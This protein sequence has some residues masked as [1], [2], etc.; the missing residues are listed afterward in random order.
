MLRRSSLLSMRHALALACAALIAASGC[1]SPIATAPQRSAEPTH[2]SAPNVIEDVS[3]EVVV[4]LAEGVSAYYV[5]YDFSATLIEWEK[6]ERCAKFIPQ[7]GQPREK[8]AYL[9]SMDPR[10]ETVDLNTYIEEVE[11]RQQ[12]FAFDDGIPGVQPYLEQA[13]ARALRLEAAHFVT[14]GRGVRVAIIDTGVDATH[15]ALAGRILMGRDFVQD[16]DDPTDVVDGVDQDGDGLADEAF[17]HGTHVA[18]LVSL[19]APEAP[20]MIARVLDADGRG[21]VLDVAAGIRW[22]TRNGARV[23]NLSLGTLDEIAAV[24]KALE[25]AEALNIVVVASAGNRGSAIPEEY[26]ARS[27]NAH[28]V[29]ATDADARPAPFTSYAPWVAISAPGV[30][31]RSAYPGG[32]YRLWSGTSMSAPFVAGAAALVIERHPSWTS[33]RVMGRLRWTTRPIQG[34]SAE[35]QGML[36]RGMLNVLAAVRA[37]HVRAGPGE[38]DEP[39]DGVE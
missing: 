3:A 36:G 8:L 38:G 20:L 7:A 1:G 33:D 29:A 13:A 21:D 22:A 28:A 12:S 2:S 26:P 34:A 18:G 10:C 32:G 30:A 16:D 24:Q 9:L 17:G 11:T 5:A 4:T 15:P 25:E 19:T 35:Q 23:I 37:D 39:T 27:N 31:V 6:D 14:R